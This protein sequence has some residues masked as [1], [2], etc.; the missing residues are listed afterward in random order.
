MILRT[1]MLS[2]IVV[3]VLFFTNLIL[4]FLGENKIGHFGKNLDVYYFIG[5]FFGIGLIFNI[6]GVIF[7]L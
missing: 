4:I 1:L 3:A 5:A 7:A 2:F 6:I